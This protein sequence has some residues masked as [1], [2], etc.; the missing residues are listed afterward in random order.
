MDILNKIRSEINDNQAVKVAASRLDWTTENGVEFSFNAVPHL[1]QSGESAEIS[2]YGKRLR[3]QSTGLQT[4]DA[5]EIN[6]V[7]M[8]MPSMTPFAQFVEEAKS[9]SP[10][11]ARSL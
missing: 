11:L 5:E 2:I 1:L 6:G 10:E 4:L 8:I 3:P 9:L 7:L